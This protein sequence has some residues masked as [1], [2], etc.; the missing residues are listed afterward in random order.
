MDAAYG[1]FFSLSPELRARFR[2][3]Q[4]ADSVTI[5]PHK[6]LFL[7]F[8]T[9]ALLVRDGLALVK[10]NSTSAEVPPYLS[11]PSHQGLP[12]S[13]QDPTS[14]YPELSRP[15]RGLRMW[16]PIKVYGVAPFTAALEEKALLAR[17]FYQEMASLPEFELGP[18][19]DLSVVLFRMASPVPDVNRMLLE[20]I[21]EEGLIFLTSTEALG[22]FWLR[23]AVLNFRTHLS[24]VR[25]AIQVIRTKARRL[26]KRGL[27]SS[28]P[29]QQSSSSSEW[30]G[31]SETSIGDKTR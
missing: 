5:D 20:V 24:D 28:R 16:L 23:M 8:G 21:N 14:L 22:K 1:G 30:L 12:S 26:A 7:P 19:P 6:S 27:P 17:Y 31:L 11:L 10:T 4:D 13:E 9:G 18:P 15:F 29:E 2:G 25:H 3:L